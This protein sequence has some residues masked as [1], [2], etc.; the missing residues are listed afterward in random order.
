MAGG[1]R[2]EGVPLAS[3]VVMTLTMTNR[4]LTAVVTR[5]DTGPA[6]WKEP[7]DTLENGWKA[8]LSRDRGR[9]NAD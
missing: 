2:Q 8:V 1:S 3:Y 9:N 5:T 7:W 4:A 6:T